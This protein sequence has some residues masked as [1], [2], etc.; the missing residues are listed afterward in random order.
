MAS[1]T[2]PSRPCVSPTNRC[3]GTKTVTYDPLAD[4]G[5]PARVAELIHAFRQRGHLAA[6]T[7][8]L[9]YRLRRHPDLN[10]SSY[11]LSLWDLDQ[12]LPHRVPGRQ[13]PCHLARNFAAAA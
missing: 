7:D 11:G 9:A 2:A 8:P 5:K 4:A 6:D 13:G 3:T 12:G 10:F 1:G